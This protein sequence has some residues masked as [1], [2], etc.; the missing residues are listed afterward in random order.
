MPP[1]FLL[2]RENGVGEGGLDMRCPTLIEV[3]EDW[4]KRGM[5]RSGGVRAQRFPVGG[6]RCEVVGVRN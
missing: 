1:S 6:K 4:R 5:E 2:L 3:M